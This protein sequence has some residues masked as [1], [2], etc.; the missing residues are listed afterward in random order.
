MRHVLVIVYYTN[1]YFYIYL[2][3]NQSCLFFCYRHGSFAYNTFLFIFVS[4]SFEGMKYLF[5]ACC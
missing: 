4:H 5:E 2:L 1:I 3:S